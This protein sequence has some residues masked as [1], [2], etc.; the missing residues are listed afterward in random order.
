MKRKEESFLFVAE[1]K[2]KNIVVLSFFELNGRLL[3]NSVS[4]HN[5]GVIQQKRPK[6]HEAVRY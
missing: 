6:G 3:L 2:L 1:K 4:I 5:L